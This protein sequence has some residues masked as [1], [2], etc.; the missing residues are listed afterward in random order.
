[1][2]P[3]RRPVLLLSSFL[4][5]LCALCGE[6][7]FA[8]PVPKQNH[9]RTIEVKL[10]PDAVVVEYHLEVDEYR[11]VRDLPREDIERIHSPEA[12]PRVF[13][14]YLAPILRDNLFARLDGK[15]LT[16]T[17]EGKRDDTVKDHLRCNFT[18]TAAWTAAPGRPHM[19]E[20]REANYDQEDFNRLYLTLTA[21]PNVSLQK[22]TAADKALLERP[23]L[24]LKPGD[25][26]R[27]RKVSATF[28]LTGAA[29]P[30]RENKG[31]APPDVA[32]SPSEENG[33]PRNL[34]HL[35]LDTR[36]GL[37]VLLLLAAGFG[38]IHAL[39]PGHGK[40]LVA[41]YL[42]G[43]RGTVWHALALGVMTTLTHTG[44]VFV[45]A[46]VFLISPEAARLISN[47]QGLIGGLFIAGL[48]LWLL[49][50]R[51]AGRADHFHL[52]G[53]SHHHHH[54]HEHPHDHEHAHADHSHGPLVAGGT[55]VRWWHLLLL[56]MRGGMVPCWDAIILLGLAISAHR[57]ELG[58]PLLLAFSAGLAGVL[59]ALGV[60]VVWARN[61]AIA[62]WGDEPRLRKLVRALPLASAALI[63]ALGLWLCYDSLH[64][65]MPPHSY[66][67]RP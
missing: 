60:G 4:C 20:F 43:E 5:A 55:S 59:V 3:S 44:A 8:H 1:M 64:P 35:L 56:G 23:P 9:D 6:S 46:L 47:V 11:A 63:T 36:R 62:R 53:H 49:L 30:K 7:V 13:M 37:A 17:G 12:I 18:F 66:S 50:R 58:I 52:G 38:A 19:F 33:P 14:E 21:E 40:T 15:K 65:E 10:K 39:T 41:A 54:P 48:G 51:L 25:S 31:T 22:V 42:V 27:L 29:E 28:V 61:W 57:L 24:E 2:E 67:A 16:F 45:L 34:L 26:E 32:A